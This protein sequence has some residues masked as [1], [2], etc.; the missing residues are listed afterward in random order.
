M[1]GGPAMC[2]CQIPP[3]DDIHTSRRE[4]AGSRTSTS[5]A[6]SWMYACFVAGVAFL[7][8]SLATGVLLAIRL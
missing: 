6:S 3:Y 2:C 1:K 8:L 5:R 4:T 7:S